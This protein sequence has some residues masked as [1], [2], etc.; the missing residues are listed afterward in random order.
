MRLMERALLTLVPGILFSGCGVLDINSCEK[1][2]RYQNSSEVAP[3][4]VPEGLT[5][6]DESR[7]LQIPDAPAETESVSKRG[8]CLESPPEYFEDG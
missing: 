4:R 7:A 2:D 8:D 6:P 1:P 3:V 5:P